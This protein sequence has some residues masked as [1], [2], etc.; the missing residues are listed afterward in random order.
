MKETKRAKIWPVLVFYGICIVLGLALGLSISASLGRGLKWWQLM[1][2]LLEGGVLIMVA[3][4]LQIVLHEAG[5]MVA[6]LMRGWSFISFMA[7]GLVLTRRNGKFHLSRF[8]IP[9]AGG[10]CLMSPPDEGVTDGD[11]AFYN[12]GGV[13]MNL[14]VSLLAGVSCVFSYSFCVWEINVL[15]GSMATVGVIFAAIN[16][17]PCTHGGL[18]N[19]GL[20]IQQLRKDKYSTHVFLASMRCIARLQSGHPVTQIM[21]DYLCNGNKKIDYANPIHVMAVN[22]DISLAIAKKDFAKAHAL[23]D[24]MEPYI[25][26]VVGIYQ[27][28]MMYEKVFLYLVS[29]REGVDV[30]KMIDSQTLKYFKMQSAFRPTTLRVHYAYVRLYEHDENKAEQVY[31]KFQKVCDSYHIPGEVVTERQLVEYVRCMKA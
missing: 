24:G 29:P 21:E 20:N 13:L 25:D 3:V 12:A 19:D 4:L 5:H 1:L 26:Q 22:M 6:G 23:F 8:A 11:I 14:F 31:Q 15:L 7:F 2:R 17:I 16:G 28:E 9:G 18:P 10:Q 27:M 30:K